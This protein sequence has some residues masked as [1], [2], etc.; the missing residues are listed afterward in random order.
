MASMSHVRRVILS[1]NWQDLEEWVGALD[2]L[3][4]LSDD[5]I[6]TLSSGTVSVEPETRAAA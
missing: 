2:Q 5:E 6:D 3:A 1:H 4:D